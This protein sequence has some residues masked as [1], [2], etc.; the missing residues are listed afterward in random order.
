[1]YL[2]YA[3]LKNYW[4]KAVVTYLEHFSVVE[5]FPLVIYYLDYANNW[6]KRLGTHPHLYFNPAPF[7]H[8]L[9]P[10]DPHL[11]PPSIISSTKTPTLPTI[12]T[13]NF[14][15]IHDSSLSCISYFS[16][17]SCLSCL[18]SL[19]PFDLSYL[20]NSFC[21][22]LVSQFNP[23]TPH[24]IKSTPLSIKSTPPSIKS[25]PHFIKSTPNLDKSTPYSNKST[26]QSI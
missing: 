4:S 15:S 25:T 21:K 10:F 8:P 22:F 6:N 5:V 9:T 16:C 2:N 18:S 1:M 11:P 7:N 24:S 14:I 19:T 3:H 20:Y 17:L 12:S 13:P 23:S 26:P